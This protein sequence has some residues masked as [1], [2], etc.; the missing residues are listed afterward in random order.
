[1]PAM[2]REYMQLAIEEAVKAGQ[3]EEV[4]V[5]AVLVDAEGV[6]VASAHNETISRRDPSAHAEMLAI[7]AACKKLDNYRLTGMRLYTTIEPCL[8]C[9]GAIIHARLAEVV[10]GAKDPKWGAAGSLYD[11]SNDPRLNHRLRIVAGV[12]GQECAGMMQA[13]FVARR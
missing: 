7:R 4:P 1:M 12:E 8:M 9:M 3:I 5:G 10:Y 2:N 6:V 11:F 13:F